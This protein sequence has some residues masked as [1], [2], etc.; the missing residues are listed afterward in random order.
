[1]RYIIFE[2]TTGVI[3]KIMMREPLR[4]D[5]VCEILSNENCVKKL[6]VSQDFIDNVVNGKFKIDIQTDEIV[7]V[8]G[9]TPPIT[10]T[11]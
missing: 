4:N 10:Q 2:R 3:T 5:D 6:S 1:M 7:E 8:D 11:I 9:W